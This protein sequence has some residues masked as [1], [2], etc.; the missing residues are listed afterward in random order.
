MMASSF[1]YFDYIPSERKKPVL[2]KKQKKQL[3]KQ[4]K[5]LAKKNLKRK[6]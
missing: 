6:K 4:K 2:L 3:K 1:S 5:A